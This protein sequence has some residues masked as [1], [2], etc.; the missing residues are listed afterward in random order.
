MTRDDA[1]RLLDAV[2]EGSQS[3]TLAQIREAL[4]LTGDLGRQRRSTDADVDADTEVE[5]GQWC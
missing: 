1:N 5:E 4:A 3:P 2:R